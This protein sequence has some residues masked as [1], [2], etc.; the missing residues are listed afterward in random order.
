MKKVFFAL[1]VSICACGVALADEAASNA[2]S[3]VTK[4]GAVTEETA[5]GEPI[6]APCEV[7]CACRCRTCYK[8]EPVTTVEKRTIKVCEKVPCKVT[9]R[10]AFWETQ[11]REI[12][13]YER[14]LVTKKVTKCCYEWVTEPCTVTRWE[15]VVTYKDVCCR[16]GHCCHKRYVTCKVACCSYNKV[17]VPGER[18]VCKPIDKEVEVKC[19]ECVPVVKEINV[20]VCECKDVEVDGFKYEPV[21][22]EIDVNVTRWVRTEVVVPCRVRHCFRHHFRRCC[23]PCVVACAPAPCGC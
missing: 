5:V 23:K 15:P 13:C 4:D 6:G 10:K 11:K 18:R 3:V 9:V 22:K 20:K 17:E 1:L 14:Q 8:W 21:E 7:S 19:W 16:V 2:S 12:T